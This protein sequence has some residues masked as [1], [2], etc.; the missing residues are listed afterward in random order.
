MFLLSE[1]IRFLKERNYLVKDVT[2]DK[3]TEINRLAS[4]AHP[5]PDALCWAKSRFR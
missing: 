5:T 2:I 1:L 4:L 3:D